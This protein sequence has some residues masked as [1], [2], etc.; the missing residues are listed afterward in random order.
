M[1]WPEAI[2]TAA[3]YL[4]IAAIIIAFIVKGDQW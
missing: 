3:A 1:N 2:A 4:A